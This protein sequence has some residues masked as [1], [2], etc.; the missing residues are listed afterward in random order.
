[1]NPRWTACLVGVVLLAAPVVSARPPMVVAQA[2]GAVIVKVGGKSTL[3]VGNVTRVAVSDPSV[4]DI[5][6]GSSDRIEVT[7]RTEGATEIVV[8]KTDGSKQSYQVTV[9]R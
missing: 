4:A 1:M 9:S 8:W 2:S 3:P 7:G 5:R 6:V